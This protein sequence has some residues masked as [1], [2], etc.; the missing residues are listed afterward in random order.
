[1]FIL[2]RLS[3]AIEPGRRG[4]SDKEFRMSYQLSYIIQGYKSQGKKEDDEE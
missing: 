2:A 4:A 3:L 1:V